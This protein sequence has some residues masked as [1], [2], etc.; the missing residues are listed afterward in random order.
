MN[1]LEKQ[2]FDFLYDGK[3]IDECP[4]QLTITT[5]E[6]TYQQHHEGRV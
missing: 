6:D 5:H 4:H 1:F 3:R 2:N